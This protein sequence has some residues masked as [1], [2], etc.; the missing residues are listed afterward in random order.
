MKPFLGIDIT[1]NE[2]STKINGEEFLV[3]KADQDDEADESRKPEEKKEAKTYESPLSPP[4]RIVKTV[5]LIIGIAIIV[6]Y[7]VNNAIF[8]AKALPNDILM[9]SLIVCFA[10]WGGLASYEGLLEDKRTAEEL[11]KQEKDEE[12]TVNDE[13]TD[14]ELSIPEGAASVDLLAFNYVI[15]DSEPKAVI[16]DGEASSEYFNYSMNLWADEDFLY[17][18]SLDEKYAI[19]RSAIQRIRAVNEKIAIPDWNKDT[20][21]TKG[22]FKQFGITVD[23]LNRIII[24]SYF[25]IDLFHQ[26]ESWGIYFPVY[27]L[28]YFEKIT[29]LHAE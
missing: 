7:V 23:T 16:A 9:Y 15:E 18:A 22:E 5:G 10:V 13:P 29:G 17:L 4:L 2:N 11:K 6:L 27:E 19:P 12:D 8:K 21:P 26:E 20:P 28:P 3:V 25:V 1:D 24:P 14:N